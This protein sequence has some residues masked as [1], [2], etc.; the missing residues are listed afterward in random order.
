MNRRQF[1]AASAAAGIA[2]GFVPL[3]AV[4]KH[5][6]T[7]LAGHIGNIQRDVRQPSISAEKL[8]AAECAELTR[9]LL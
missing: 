8:G 7:N 3:D 6:N 2:R 5:I 9:S 1:V 4:H